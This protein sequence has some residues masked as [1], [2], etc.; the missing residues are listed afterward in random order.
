MDCFVRDMAF[1]YTTGTMFAVLSDDRNTGALAQMDLKTGLFTVV[2]DTGY[3]MVALACDNR[4][5][6]YAVDA[7][8]NMYQ[9]NK[10]TAEATYRSSTSMSGSIY[11]SMHYDYNNDTIYWARTNGFGSKLMRLDRETGYAVSLGTIDAASGEQKGVGIEV[12]SLFSIPAE[13]PAT[14]ATLQATGVRL[15]EA[16]AAAV[17]K[18]FDA[19]CHPS[20]GERGPGGGEP[21]LDLQ[22]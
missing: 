13:E 16:M 7:A 15:P 1:D 12:T 18:R 14:P 8:G 20:A 9:L 19:A 5:I 3:E 21:Y 11:Q 6:L 10:D 4:G 22:R 17:G 2:G